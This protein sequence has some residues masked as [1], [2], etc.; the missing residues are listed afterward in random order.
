MPYD[1][2]LT[3]E[4]CPPRSSFI[5]PPSA[6]GVIKERRSDPVSRYAQLQQ[7][8]K[9]QAPPGEKNRNDVRW[10]VRENMLQA[11]MQNTTERKRHD[12]THSANTYVVPTT[13]KR[14]AL[15][16]AVR[17]ALLSQAV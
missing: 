3:D 4:N 11:R 9:D 10:K 13:K 2:K 8:W 5:V 15:R 17:E 14:S 12:Y 6:R 7:A 1:I 16:W